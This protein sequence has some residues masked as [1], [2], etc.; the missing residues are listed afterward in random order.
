MLVFI[1]FFSFLITSFKIIYVNIQKKVLNIQQA[2]LAAIEKLIISIYKYVSNN[3]SK[4]KVPNSTLKSI[5]FTFYS[6]WFAMMAPTC[7]TD[8]WQP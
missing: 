3:P 2:D 1:F 6:K 4:A 7:R 5:C 8:L